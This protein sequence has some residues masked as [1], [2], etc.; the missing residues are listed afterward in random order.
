MPPGFTCQQVARSGTQ[1]F[2][3][4]FI[5]GRQVVAAAFPV[6]T[7]G[8]KGHLIT[9]NGVSYSEERG[10]RARS[11]FSLIAGGIILISVALATLAA[12]IVVRWRLSKLQRCSN[13]ALG[14]S[15]R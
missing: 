7:P 1:S 15:I 9:L 11:Y 14:T 5:G 13:D 8:A 3:S 10:A 6:Q 2:Y 4:L 12:L